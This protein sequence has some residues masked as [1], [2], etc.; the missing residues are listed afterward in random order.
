MLPRSLISFILFYTFFTLSHLLSYIFKG[1][2]N[3]IL[4]GS[5]WK[6]VDLQSLYLIVTITYY[7][8]ASLAFQIHK[9]KT[10]G[11]RFI[12]KFVIC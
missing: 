8:I 7:L 5:S 6:K 1:T 2:V 4:N 11:E 9:S 3:L 10:A 12:L